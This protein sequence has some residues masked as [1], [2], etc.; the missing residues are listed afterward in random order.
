MNSDEEVWQSGICH[1]KDLW[2]FDKL[3]LS[4]RLGYMCGPH[5]VPVPYPDTYICR[6]CVNFYG[7]GLGVEIKHIED[8]TDYVMNPGTFWCE[9]FE[10]RH[11]SID[12][13]N[14]KQ[15]LCV[16]GIYDEKKYPRFSKWKKV[17]DKVP[18]P[19]IV[20][21]LKGKYEWINIETIG[22][23]VIEIHLRRNPDFIGH[24]SD[25]VIPVWKWDRKQPNSKQIF[26]EAPA[27]N[28]LGFLI[29]K[30]SYES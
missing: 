17:Q 21:K 14:G 5:G 1:E 19:E 4:R 23:N 26:V 12:Y 18:M 29:R 9:I 25:Y 28:R 22:G 15:V 8:S 27:G 2:I 30:G 3:L 7:M 13:H 11:L 20:K 10:G 6:P 16:E 24:N